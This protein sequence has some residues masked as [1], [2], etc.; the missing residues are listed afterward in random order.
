MNAL[1]EDQMVRL[2]RTLDSDEARANMDRRLA[3]NRIFF[4]QY[5]GETPVTGYEHHP[6]LARE[7]AEK[8]RRSRRLGQL[9]E[10]LRSYDS[11]QAAARRHDIQR[12]LRSLDKTRFIFPSLDGGEMTSRWDMQATPP[13]ILVT[14]ASM[15]GAMLSR[16]VEQGM[17]EQTRQWLIGNDDAYFSWCL[18]NFTSFAARREL[19]CHF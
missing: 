18:T 6:R 15:L 9:R 8:K 11:D 17:F 1:V 14:N 16:E 12:G 5:T 13:D 3:G 19:K 4:G 7:D 2:R 10:A